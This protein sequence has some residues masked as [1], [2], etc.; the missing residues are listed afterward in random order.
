M[1]VFPE[2]I[3]IWISRLHKADCPSSVGGLHQ[4]CWGPTKSWN[5]GEFALSA[6]L[7]EWEHWSSPAL[8]LDHI[9]SVP[10]AQAF[11][12]ELHS[13]MRSPCLLGLQLA[14][15]KSWNLIS[16]YSWMSQFLIINLSLYI[17]INTYLLP[18]TLENPNT[19]SN[20]VLWRLEEIVFVK[21]PD[22]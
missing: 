15:A 13:Y 11:R 10:G 6:S 16:V 4:I 12:L 1:K 20:S 17:N 22:T 9:P 8:G 14:E 2:E 21:M 19:T 18:A 3:S 7:F 5:K